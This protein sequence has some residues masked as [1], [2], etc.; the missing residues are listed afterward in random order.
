MNLSIDIIKIILVILHIIDKRNFIQ[1]C[2]YLNQLFP[3]MKHFELE[4]VTMLNNSQFVDLNKPV[5]NQ[6]EIYTLEYIYYD[7]IN[8]PEKY[9]KFNNRRLFTTYPKLYFSIANKNICKK[10]YQKYTEHLDQIMYRALVEA[11]LK[12]VKWAYQNGF[13]SKY[14]IS[15]PGVIMM[16]LDNYAEETVPSETRLSMQNKYLEILKWVRGNGLVS[17]QEASNMRYYLRIFFCE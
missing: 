1:S 10:I 2:K 5:F 15:M 3:L 11:D 12:M 4:F 16:T 9:L 17:R 7:R 8:I 13:D 14:N 6:L